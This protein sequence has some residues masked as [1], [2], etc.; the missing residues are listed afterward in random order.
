MLTLFSEASLP[1]H[2][3]ARDS[4]GMTPLHWAALQGSPSVL[5]LL[6]QNCPDARAAWASCR[7]GPDKLTP[8][9][10]AERRAYLLTHNGTCSSSGRAEQPGMR[11]S[12]DWSAMLA[13]VFTSAWSS[14]AC[15]AALAVAVSCTV[16]SHGPGR[17]YTFAAFTALAAV[18]GLHAYLQH[19]LRSV[20][21]L[22]ELATEHGLRLSSGL[23]LGGP[24]QERFQ[25]FR[26]KRCHLPDASAAMTQLLRAAPLMLPLVDSFSSRQLS[27]TWGVAVAAVVLL[28]VCRRMGWTMHRRELLVLNALADCF[29]SVIAYCTLTGHGGDSFCPAP[30]P[31]GT[32]ASI[33]PAVC[34][35]QA[36]VVTRAA[37]LPSS[38]SWSV[39]LFCLVLASSALLDALALCSNSIAAIMAPRSAIRGQLSCLVALGASSAIQLSWLASD[40]H[41]FLESGPKGAPLRKEAKAE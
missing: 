21:K 34:W 17:R 39:F 40:M 11:P 33:V 8:A 5:K 22:Q 36:A 38:P 7:A 14:V 16:H 6:L 3:A 9:Q 30:P 1:V 41:E 15:G 35:L 19:H 18:G 23:R 26:A 31:P 24:A 27:N 32:L 37:V 4:V 29:V 12:A 2:A 20:R 10:M 13:G 28:I 25:A